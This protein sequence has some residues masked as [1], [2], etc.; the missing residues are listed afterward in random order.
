M[1]NNQFENE[2][3]IFA[4]IALFVYLEMIVILFCNCNSNAFFSMIFIVMLHLQSI[5][6]LK[7]L[8]KK[9]TIL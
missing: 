1:K 9:Y 6:I 5:C 8:K 3:E 2:N 7:A 4:K